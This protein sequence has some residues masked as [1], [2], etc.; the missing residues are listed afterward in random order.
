M[1][2]PEKKGIQEKLKFEKKQQRLKRGPKPI[3]D[4]KNL[5]FDFSKKKAKLVEKEEREL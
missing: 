2:T 3:D 5:S 1:P 4:G